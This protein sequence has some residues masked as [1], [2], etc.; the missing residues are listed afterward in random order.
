[1][2]ARDK[3]SD[4]QFAAQIIE[5][6]GLHPLGHPGSGQRC[7]AVERAG[8]VPPPAMPSSAALSAIQVSA[9]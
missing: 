2:P 3:G 4:T 9:A 7:A 6:V 8:V 1:L 5:Q